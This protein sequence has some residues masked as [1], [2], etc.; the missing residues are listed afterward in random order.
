MGLCPLLLFA[1]AASPQDAGTPSPGPAAQVRELLY[2]AERLRVVRAATE[3]ELI[4]LD[5]AGKPGADAFAGYDVVKRYGVI[6]PGAVGPLKALLLED[7]QLQFASKLCGGF[8]PGVGLRFRASSAEPADVLLCFACDDVAVPKGAVPLDTADM[9]ATRG[10]LLE[11]LVP[12]MPG[13]EELGRVLATDRR[14]RAAKRMVAEVMRAPDPLRSF[15]PATGKRRRELLRAL[16][17]ESEH[18][19]ATTSRLDALLSLFRALPAADIAALLKPSDDA[20]LRAGVARA[21]LGEGRLTELPRRQ[22]LALFPVLAGHVLH[23][24]PA[25]ARPEVL[26]QVAANDSPALRR[27]LRGAL[28]KPVDPAWGDGVGLRGPSVRAAVLLTLARL[29]EDGGLASAAGDERDRLALSVAEAW[30]HPD[31]GLPEGA[32]LSQDGFVFDAAVEW[33][34]RHPGDAARAALEQAGQSHPY[35]GSAAAARRALQAL[36]SESSR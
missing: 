26:R 28:K 14:D 9:S 23:W 4:R 21:L 22:Q 3:V 16:G 7:E 31:R 2:G 32:L 30:L 12:L 1:L 36:G 10:A 5:P 20:W 18:W 8:K 19:S 17:A 15:G 34:K 11:L 24:G 29:G 27:A 25:D 33:V 35:P 6:P 13:D